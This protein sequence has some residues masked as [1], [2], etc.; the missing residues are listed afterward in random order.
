MSENDNKELS[1]FFQC[2]GEIWRDV[3]AI[4]F[5][6]RCAIAQAEGDKIHS[7]HLHIQK[8]VSIRNILGRL[9]QFTLKMW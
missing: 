9:H 8:E 1:D 7:Q 5:L 4:E 3:A 6:M 2:L